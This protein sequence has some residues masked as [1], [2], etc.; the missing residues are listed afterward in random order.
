MNTLNLISVRNRLR[1][2]SKEE[3]SKSLKAEINE[4]IKQPIYPLPL[5]SL[6]PKKLSMRDFKQNLTLIKLGGNLR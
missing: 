2:F 6:T 5:A 3:I 1:N 4:E